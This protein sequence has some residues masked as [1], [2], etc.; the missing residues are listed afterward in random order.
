MADQLYLSVGELATR[1]SVSKRTIWRWVAEGH[2]PK[3]EELPGN[4]RRWLLVDVARIEEAARAANP[5]PTRTMVP[6]AGEAGRPAVAVS[7]RA[8]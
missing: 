5:N 8:T 1:Y 2:L 7:P 3:P 6:A 4:I